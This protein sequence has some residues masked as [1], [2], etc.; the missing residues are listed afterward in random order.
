MVNSYLK[1]VKEDMDCFSN[2]E[3]STVQKYKY[4]C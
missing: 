1:T 4:E 3:F 2:T